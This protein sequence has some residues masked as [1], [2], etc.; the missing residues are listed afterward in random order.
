MTKK[1]NGTL[2]HQQQV[3]KEQSSQLLVHYQKNKNWIFI[4][5][6]NMIVNNK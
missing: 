3:L 6:V 5:M 2:Q 4:E 1:V